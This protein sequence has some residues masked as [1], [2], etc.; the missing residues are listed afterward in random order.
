MSK[1]S[2]LEILPI[3]ASIK[4]VVTVTASCIALAAVAA[5]AAPAPQAP[6]PSTVAETSSPT[7]QVLP[8]F[9]ELA[10]RVKPA[11]VSLNVKRIG[12]TEDGEDEAQSGTNPFEGTPFEKFFNRKAPEE[13]RTPNEKSLSWV[14]GSGFFISAD[15]FAVTN[16]HVVDGARKVEVIGD[17]GKRYSARV[18][19]VDPKTDLALIKAEGRADFPFVKLASAKPR[20]GE[21]AMAVGNP[22]GLGGTVTTGIVS[23]EGRDI[24]S[25]PYD[26]FIQIDAPINKGNSGGPTFNL[27]GEV[28]GVNTAIFSPSGGSVGI[29][30]DIPS[31]MVARIIPTLK[32]KGHIDRG[33]LGVAVQDVTQDVADSVGLAEARGALVSEPVAD[34]PA[35]KAGLHPGDVITVLNGEAVLNAHDLARRIGDTKPNTVVSMTVVRQG[36]TKQ[37]RVKIAK[38]K[39]SDTLAMNAGPGQ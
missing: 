5:A 26:D 21:W 33:W 20:I 38:D 35:A 18:I 32:E 7:G 4:P 28:I 15:G 8:D 1:K 9:A 25:G 31:H 24:G 22:F 3:K 27:R 11:V 36:S 39:E 16:N 13:K 17:D 37:L 29:A 30:F 34:G 6:A 2:F 19:G 23:A 14:A 10:A 12:A